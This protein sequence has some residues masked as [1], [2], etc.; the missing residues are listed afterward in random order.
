MSATR[1]KLFT[2]GGSQAV[3][4]PKEFRFEGA[5]VEVSRE[6][7]TVL[8]KPVRR[9]TSDLW[10]EIDE[11]RGTKLA[12]ACTGAPMPRAKANTFAALPARI[13]HWAPSTTSTRRIALTREPKSVGQAL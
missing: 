6:G 8:L 2:H 10:K 4:L 11:R 5:E 13:R 3:R 9:R 12:A 7:D 1:A